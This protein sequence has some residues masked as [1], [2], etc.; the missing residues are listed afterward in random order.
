M[1]KEIF[2]E[3][4]EDGH[5]KHQTRGFV[6]NACMV[7]GNKFRAF[8]KGFGIEAESEQTVS[9]PEMYQAENGHKIRQ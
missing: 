1:V 8:L 6:G 2:V 7:F 9:T 4:D 3:I 5:I